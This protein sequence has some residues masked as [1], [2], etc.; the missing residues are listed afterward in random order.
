M[1]ESVDS[2]VYEFFLKKKNWK[3]NQESS[4]LFQS[5]SQ[6]RNK[7]LA[8]DR[9]IQVTLTFVNDIFFFHHWKFSLVVH[10]I[11]V[12]TDVANNDVQSG[13]T[14]NVELGVC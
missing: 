6:F 13:C 3:R 4:F 8:E 2:R 1:V 14:D 11:I 12:E 5:H 10:Q 9:R 7:T